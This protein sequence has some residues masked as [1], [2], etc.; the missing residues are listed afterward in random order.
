MSTNALLTALLF[1]VVPPQSAR[2]YLQAVDCSI[3]QGKIGLPMHTKRISSELTSC[4]LTMR[5]CRSSGSRH[6][7]ISPG[8]FGAAPYVGS[9]YAVQSYGGGGGGLGNIILLAVGAAIVYGLV[10][11]FLDN[12][13]DSDSAQDTVE[14]SSPAS[15]CAEVV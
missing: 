4:D 8:W 5:P 2:C 15:K 11:S 9:G 3:Q 7:S 14:G 1:H 6:L 12:R 10:S 13:S